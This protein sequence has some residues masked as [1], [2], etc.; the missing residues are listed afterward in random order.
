MHTHLITEDAHNFLTRASRATAALSQLL[1]VYSEGAD[2][3]VGSADMAVFLDYIR[4]DI[5]S[6]LTGCD[7]LPGRAPAEPLRVVL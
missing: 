6:G 7:V 5:E 3:N 1:T 4:M 2:G